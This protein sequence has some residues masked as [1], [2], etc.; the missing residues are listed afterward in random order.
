MCEGQV[1]KQS[2]AVNVKPTSGTAPGTLLSAEVSYFFVSL[3]AGP[4]AF[5]NWRVSLSLSCFNIVQ[6]YRPYLSVVSA[7]EHVKSNIISFMEKLLFS[8]N[9]PLRR[10]FAC[11]HGSLRL[12]E[13]IIL[14]GHAIVELVLT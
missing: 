3:S 8:S 7:C 14:G 13:A 12:P 6:I 2:E 10:A 5:T 11:L 9:S 1:L 4:P